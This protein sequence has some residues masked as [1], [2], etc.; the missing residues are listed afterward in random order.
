[1]EFGVLGGVTYV[2]YIN[3]EMAAGS[4]KHS[5]DVQRHIL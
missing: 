2:P 1:M 3:L 5:I 4:W